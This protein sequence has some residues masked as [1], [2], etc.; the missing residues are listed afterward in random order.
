M[1]AAETANPIDRYT[2]IGELSMKVR[3]AVRRIMVPLT[4][5]LAMES[6]YLAIMDRPGATAFFLMAVGT[7]G[8]LYVWSQTG[9]GLPLMPVMAIQ[10]LFIYGVP[11]AAGHENILTYPPK[12]VFQASIEVLVFCIAM[13]VSWYMAMKMLHPSPPV[14]H[15]MNEFNRE[16][17]KGWG[18]L[19]FGMIVATTGFEVLRGVGFLDAVFSALPSGM[20]AMI[21]TLISV[22]SACGF[23]LVSMIVGANEASTFEK[24]IFWLL[25]I[26]NSMIASMDFILASAAA[27]LITVAIGLFWSSG[28]MPLGYL[29]VALL[30]LSFLNTGKTNM[31]ARYWEN[32]YAPATLVTF[33]QLPAVFLEWVEVSYN[34][35]LEN[36]VGK[37]QGL[38]G[39]AEAKKNQTLLDRI[40]NL[41]NLLFVID[42][43]E[44]EHISLLGG[45]TYSLIPPLLV[46]RVL[47]PDKPRSHEGQ[48]MLNVHY[49]RQD[50]EST[51][52]TYIA[53]GLL[54]EAYGNFGPIAG[55]SILG[56]FLGVFFALVENLTAR[57]LVMSMEGFL[58][59][60]L[61]MN[62]MNSFEM[63]ASVLV[64]S[65]FQ[66]MVIIVLA[67]MPFVRRTV[68]QRPKL[69]E[70]PPT[71]SP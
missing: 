26:A 20:D 33:Q 7:I 66:S 42:A 3:S 18:R 27:N 56:I 9:I 16:G 46:P 47:W 70:D 21:N 8:A 6:A 4:V 58:C 28:R 53:W 64:T 67:S 23:L 63:V 14:S 40:D 43:T 2:E 30:S 69:E 37:Q 25:L 19:G 57:K 45:S 65:T 13:S 59:F 34:A 51:F 12:F 17:V 52:V 44:T 1:R 31:R 11:I 39:V 50:I 22:L 55:A 54:P 10:S 15:A 5:L 38:A 71:L 68:N 29:T 62:L 35:V 60:S 41:Q 32:D 61:L 24:V 49:G 36:N 48:I